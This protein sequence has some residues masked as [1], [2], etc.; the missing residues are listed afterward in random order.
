MESL[1]KPE[2]IE[3]TAENA[4]K[5]TVKILETIML[6]NRLIL[7]RLDDM[8]GILGKIPAVDVPAK[9]DND[10]ERNDDAGC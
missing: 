6:Q 5:L 1:Q 10:G 9:E 8:V 2:K 7:T 4:P 3:V